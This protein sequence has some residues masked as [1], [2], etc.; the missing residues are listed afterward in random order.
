MENWKPLRERS[1]AEIRDRA[2]QYR[3]MAE[4]ARDADTMT[5]LLDLADRF[6]AVADE[7]DASLQAA[8]AERQTEAAN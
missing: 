8:A 6:D 1:P 2:R 4:T 7:R 5:V 3:H